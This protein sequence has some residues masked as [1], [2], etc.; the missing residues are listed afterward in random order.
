MSAQAKLEILRLV[1]ASELPVNES[2]KRLGITSSTYYRW[3]KRYR[4]GGRDNLQDRKS[5]AKP[6]N[7]LLSQ[8]KDVILEVATLYPEWSSRELACFLSDH[9]GFTVSESTVFRILKKQGLIH[10]R[11]SKTFPAGPEYKVKTSRV[12]QQW[13]T[14]A[15][16]L[17]A[18]NWGLVL[19]NFGTG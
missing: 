1:E 15:T 4:Q 3:C 11:E 12:N 9:R 19:P 16:Y 6:W 7:S 18:K 17:L 13:Q 14:D 10:S 8:E 2:L 5:F